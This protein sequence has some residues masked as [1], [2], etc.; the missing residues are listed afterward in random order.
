MSFATF[1]CEMIRVVVTY[2]VGVSFNFAP[3]DT[4]HLRNTLKDGLNIMN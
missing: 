1:T 2:V 4:T 3:L